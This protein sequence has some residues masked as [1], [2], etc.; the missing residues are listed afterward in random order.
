MRLLAMHP[1]ITVANQ[2]PYETFALEFWLHLV[3]DQLQ[4]PHTFLTP[5]DQKRFKRDFLCNEQKR[6]WFHNEYYSRATNFCQQAIEDYYLQVSS[7]QNINTAR[8]FAEKIPY[9]SGDGATT[10]RQLSSVVRELYP[11]SKEIVLVRD[12]RDM[13]LS[14][15]YFGARNRIYVDIENEK[16]TAYLNVIKEVKEFSEY[17]RRHKNNTLLIRYEDLLLDTPSTLETIFTYLDIPRDTA[18]LEAIIR[19]RFKVDPPH[20][21]HITSISIADSVQRW[22]QELTPQ[23]QGKYTDAFRYDLHLFGYDS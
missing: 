20:Q 13:V 5:V 15:L 21:Q 23:L 14:A 16:P 8:Y 12:F 9:F 19:D 10:W 6:S 22:K 17:Y 2:H 3:N 11:T 1:S 7:E 18:T 4:A